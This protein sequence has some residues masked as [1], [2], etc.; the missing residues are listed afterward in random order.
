MNST[1]TITQSWE[2]QSILN[3]A[4]DLLATGATTASTGQHIAA[5]LSLNRS[6]LLPVN[7]NNP[8]HA[9]EYLDPHWQQLVK[10]AQLELKSLY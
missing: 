5:A 4:K 7:Y 10:T 6:D 8:I 1:K 9:W 2:L 3:T